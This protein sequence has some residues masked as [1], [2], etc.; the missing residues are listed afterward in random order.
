MIER[1]VH[2]ARS[3]LAG[4]AIQA[5]CLECPAIAPVPRPP[6]EGDWLTRFAA[7]VLRG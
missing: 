5:R 1:A 4:A 3:L 6:V 7:L 2:E